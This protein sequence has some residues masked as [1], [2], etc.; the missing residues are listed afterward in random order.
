LKPNLFQPF[1]FHAIKHPLNSPLERCRSTEAVADAC[2]QIRQFFPAAFI[3]KR[4]TN[5]TAGHIAV[6][7]I[8]RFGFLC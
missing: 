2:R 8:E 1:L 3:D 4:C 6:I 5:Q 7:R